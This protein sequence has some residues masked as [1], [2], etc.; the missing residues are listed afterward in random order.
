MLLWTLLSG[1]TLVIPVW[2]LLL[3]STLVLPV[4]TLLSGSTST[5][6]MDLVLP[7]VL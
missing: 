4:W 5:S 6:C 7:V 2:P 3:G 1:G